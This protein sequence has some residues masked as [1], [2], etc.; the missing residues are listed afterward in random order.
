MCTALL[1]VDDNGNVLLVGVRDEMLARAWEP[2]ARHWPEL[3]SLIGGRDLQAGGTWL[4]VS[5]GDRRAAC[6]LNG[7]GQQAP[8]ATRRSRGGLPL[9]AALG[10]P[11]DRSALA[12]LDPFHLLV[13]EPGRAT[14]ASWDGRDLLDRELSPGLHLAVNSGLASDLHPPGPHPPAPHPPAPASGN[15]VSPQPPSA[16]NGR[17]RELARIAYFLPRFTQ[18]AQ[19]D[20]QA[21]Q[22]IGEAWGEWFQLINGAGLP[23]DDQRALIVRHDFGDGRVWGSGSISLVALSPAGLRYDFT[24]SPGDPA[25]WYPV[26][27]EPESPDSSQS[28]ESPESPASPSS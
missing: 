6:V 5:P 18:A 23:T 10:K 1:S 26:A 21:G 19:P 22:P 14:I 16:E 28:P 4:A 12:E 15:P 27:H 25:A 24:A 20:P 13:A 8:A 17:A 2:P 7:R 11:L 9:Q 3:P